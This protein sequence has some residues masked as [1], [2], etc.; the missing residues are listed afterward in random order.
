MMYSKMIANPEVHVVVNG[1]IPE[2][3]AQFG[4]SSVQVTQIIN[5][6]NLPVQYGET[7]I[8]PRAHVMLPEERCEICLAP[9]RVVHRQGEDHVECVNAMYHRFVGLTVA[10]NQPGD[11]NHKQRRQLKRI[12]RRCLH[13]HSKHQHVK[14]T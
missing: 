2:E 11:Y 4:V 8:V 5:P 7:R 1:Y 6:G 13:I 12:A 10:A 14:E 9:C 3:H